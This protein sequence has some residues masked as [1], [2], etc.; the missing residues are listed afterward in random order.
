MNESIQIKVSEG[1]F[2]D[3][4]LG[5]YASAPSS[6]DTHELAAWCGF[7]SIAEGERR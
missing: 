7:T 4:L 1:E 6:N 2:D 3:I 5:E